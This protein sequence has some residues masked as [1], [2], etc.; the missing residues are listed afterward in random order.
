MGG[1]TVFLTPAGDVSASTYHP[2]FQVRLRSLSSTVIEIETLRALSTGVQHT[3]YKLDFSESGFVNSTETYS[4]P[5]GTVQTVA[6]AR[7]LWI[8]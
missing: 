5:L 7:L 6:T 3:V 1:I 2:E 4:Y 8:Q